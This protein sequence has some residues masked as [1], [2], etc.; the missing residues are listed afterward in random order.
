VTFNV[1]DVTGR[2]VL[3]QTLA[4]GRTGTA[5]LDLRKL[6][7]GVYLVKVTTEGFS[8]TQKLVLQH[9]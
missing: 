9:R 2:T 8:S 1:F 5:G 3:E 7:A 4:A 6:E